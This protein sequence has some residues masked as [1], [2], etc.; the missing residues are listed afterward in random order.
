[1]TAGAR[2]ATLGELRAAGILEIRKGHEVGS[3]AYGT[4]DVPFVRTSDVVNFEISADPTKSVSEEIYAEYA[5]QQ[6]LRAGSIVMV[7]DGR[8]RIGATAILTARSARCV[9]QSHLR[10]LDCVQPEV[11]DPYA[12]LLALNLP[13]VRR[14][15]R[16]L[17]FIQSTLGTL[18]PRLLELK[19]PLLQGEGPWTATLARFRASLEQR[20]RMLAAIEE[21]VGPEIE[22]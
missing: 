8:Y 6:R 11:L 17:V 4:G 10:I 12:L 15:I 18:G 3:E 20:D 7:V 9:V 2:W 13:G 19:I 1:M 16:D 14:R 22:L 5:P 21:I